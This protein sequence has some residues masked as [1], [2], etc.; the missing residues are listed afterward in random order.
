MTD[1]PFFLEIITGVGAGTGYPLAEGLTAIGRNPANNAVLPSSEML[2][3]GN[4]AIVYRTGSTLL[5]QD[6]DSTNG[7][8]VNGEKVTEKVLVSGDIIWLGKQG[9]RL[10][11]VSAGTETDELCISKAGNRGSIYSEIPDTEIM[12]SP[13]DGASSLRSSVAKRSDRKEKD[14]STGLP[15]V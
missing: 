3:S 11:L 1:S 7:T 4:H 6:M 10:R 12:G 9:P 13:F 2:V 15:L 8:Y 5:L 14:T